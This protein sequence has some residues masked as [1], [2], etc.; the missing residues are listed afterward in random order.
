MTAAG[1]YIHRVNNHLLTDT[2]VRPDDDSGVTLSSK[3]KQ[4]S[5]YRC[6]R[7]LAFFTFQPSPIAVTWAPAGMGKAEAL[8]HGSV[9]NCF[10]YSNLVMSDA[11]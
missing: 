1:F 11:V 9:V 3:S 4:G 2:H 8:A 10:V 7:I 5:V 6:G